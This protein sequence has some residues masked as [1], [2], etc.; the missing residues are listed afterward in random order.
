MFAIKIIEEWFK[1][2][3]DELVFHGNGKNLNTVANPEEIVENN[4]W[5]KLSPLRWSK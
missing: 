1:T 2:K 5:F 3:Q 4:K